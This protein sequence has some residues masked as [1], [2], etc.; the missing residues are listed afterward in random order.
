MNLQETIRRILR[1]ENENKAEIRKVMLVGKLIKSIYPNFNKEGVNINITGQFKHDMYSVVLIYSD[2]Q[3]DEW[4][5]KYDHDD[6]QLQLNR[7]VFETLN[8]I[9][10]DMMDY[11]VDWFNNEFGE[12]AEYVTF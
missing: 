5:V 2:K 1:E 8:S 11:V 3:T 4:Y 7:E 10:G 9:L 12:D 6:Y